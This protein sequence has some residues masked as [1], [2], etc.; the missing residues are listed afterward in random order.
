LRKT[1]KREEEKMSSS[2][3]HHKTGKPQASM[4]ER[5]LDQ[6][7]K[8]NALTK[9]SLRNLATSWNSNG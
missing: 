4:K 6:L 9:S 3:S 2:Q 1:E 5:R 7:T 8:S